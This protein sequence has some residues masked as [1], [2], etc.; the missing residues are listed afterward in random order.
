MYSKFIRETKCNI[1]APF[2]S[3]SKSD[4]GLESVGTS[5]DVRSLTVSGRSELGGNADEDE[6]ATYWNK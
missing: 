1:F 5:E 3:L 6:D 4:D 2:I